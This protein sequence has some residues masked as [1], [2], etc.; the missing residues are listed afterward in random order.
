MICINQKDFQ[1]RSNQ[2]SLMSQIYAKATKVVAW[3]GAP[4]DASRMVMAAI[5]SSEPQGTITGN[6][7]GFPTS[8][9]VGAFQAFLSRPYFSRIWIIQEVAK[10]K[11]VELWCGH[12][13]VDFEDFLSFLALQNIMAV[14]KDPDNQAAHLKTVQSFRE[15]ELRSRRGLPRMLL[16]QALVESWSSKSTDPRDKMYALLG[17]TVDGGDIIDYPSYTKSVGEVFRSAMTSMIAEQGHTALILLARGSSGSQYASSWM[18]DPNR[19]P[20]LPPWVLESLRRKRDSYD[21]AVSISQERLFILGCY[22]DTVE[23]ITQDSFE[24][25][26]NEQSAEQKSQRLTMR[27]WAAKFESE[28]SLGPVHELLTNSTRGTSE[29]DKIEAQ[30]IALE[31]GV[32]IAAKYSMRLM[33]LRHRGFRMVHQDAQHGD[34][35]FR[36]ENCPLPV[37][38]RPLSN[39]HYRLVGEVYVDVREDEWWK[40][41]WED[42]HMDEPDSHFMTISID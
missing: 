29:S 6:D 12:D 32:R 35:I 13:S 39:H 24:K 40:T 34:Q 3:L 42:F 28:P 14:I 1:E 23:D 33:N 25:R 37:V 31:R 15:R 18:I 30:L 36:L 19:R 10:A 16:S 5:A 8:K 38:L 22:L 26:E 4:D 41:V 20:P 9:V 17:L 11:S 7:D 2:V 27:D 21:Y